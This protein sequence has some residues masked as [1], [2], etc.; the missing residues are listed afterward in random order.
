MTVINTNIAA[1]ITANSMKSNARVMETAMERLSTGK[2]INSASD[3]AAGLAI[4]TRMT[5]QIRGL[6]QATRSSNDGI[7]MLQTAD[8]ALAEI[9]EMFQRMREISVQSGSGTLT[10]ADKSNLNQE[11]M[12]LAQEI[13]RTATDTTFNNTAILS[14]ATAYKIQVGADETDVIT[15]TTKDM[16][17]NATA[18]YNATVSSIN[19]GAAQDL[20]GFMTDSALNP[21]DTGTIE[22]LDDVIVAIASERASYG[23]TIN[24]LEYAVD[25]LG[26]A[27]LNTQA[28]RSQIV[29]ADYASETTEL[30][31]TQIIAQA[32]TAMLSQANQ[33]AQSVLA[34]LK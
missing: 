6:Q 1:S 18:T 23:A 11:F 29:D 21:D 24:R 12:A 17:L 31:R 33:Q 7:A 14:S 5:S 15:F 16:Q 26:A 3:D 32:S 4:E 13:D 19:S 9:G 10:D 22:F 27:V 2:R 34:L 25:T 8:G 28:A 30:A 20:D